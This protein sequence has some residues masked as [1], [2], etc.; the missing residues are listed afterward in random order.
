M[1]DPDTVSYN[2]VLAGFQSSHDALNFASKMNFSGILFD[3]VSYSTTLGLCLDKVGFQFGYQLHSMAKKSGLLGEVYVGNAFITVYSRWGRI[4]EAERVFDEMLHRD[5]VS[6]NALLSGCSQEG[7]YGLKAIWAFCEMIRQ[8]M[9]VDHVSFTSAVSAC[10]HER[11]L[12]MGR[13]IHGLS[14][15]VGFGRHVS[16]CNVLMSTYV[17]S[18]AVED[19]KQVFHDI[20]DRNVVSWT[21]MMSIS[22]DD[23]LPLFREMRLDGY[24]QNSLYQEALE[25]FSSAVLESQPNEYT[26]GSILSAI[27]TAESISLRQGQRCHSHLLKLGFNTNPIVSGALLDMYAK[28]GSL[29]ESRLVFQETSERTQVTWTTI[30]SAHARHG[31]YDSVMH[32]F[33]EM[34][35]QGV[36]PDSIT[37]LSVLTSCGRKGM[38]DM[39]QHIF[40]TYIS[41]QKIVASTEH[42]ACM[43][44]M[45]GRAGKLK[46]AEDLVHQIPSGAPLSALQSLLGACRI[47]GD[48]EMGQ[49][50]ANALM[51]M[52]PD[53][54][55]S[56][57]LMSNLYA[58]KGDWEK[59]AR[60]RRRMRDKGVK[61]EIGFSWVDVGVVDGT[62]YM[63]GFSSD[64]TSHPRSEEIYRIAKSLGLELKFLEREKEILGLQRKQCS[65]EDK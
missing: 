38:V 39:G 49:R 44:D 46:E 30:M 17:K 64:D 37:L 34:E 10:G 9:K 65:W 32:L 60:I 47:H 25:M 57:V 11:N 58:A 4:P 45:L 12:E 29:S 62:L 51:E 52:E 22:E 20:G 21:T 23:V 50:V 28:R 61:K 19:A 8:G 41:E 13:Q 48:V 31:D 55:G 54:S 27:G 6:W 15:K 36:K 53:E 35:S 56:Y 2:T 63:H 40:N 43:V 59:V 33:K 42:Y 14:I 3:P 24:T 5:L 18:E 1:D 7:S 26:F 16:V